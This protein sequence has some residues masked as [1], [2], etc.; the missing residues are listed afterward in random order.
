[1]QKKEI[2][3]SDIRQ[4]YEE[5]GDAYLLRRYVVDPG[6]LAL[7]YLIK[8]NLDKIN[9][10]TILD[11]GCGPGILTISLKFGG[12]QT[13][14]IDIA[15]SKLRKLKRIID[16]ALAAGECFPFKDRSMDIVVCTEVLEHVLYPERVIQEILRVTKDYAIISFPSRAS[17]AV[18]FRNSIVVNRTK[19]LLNR[20]RNVFRLAHRVKNNQNKNQGWQL[21]KGSSGHLRAIKY[22]QLKKWAK[23]YDFKIIEAVGYGTIC[24]TSGANRTLE[25]FNLFSSY[26]PL[27]RYF[28]TFLVAKI[29]PFN[30]NISSPLRIP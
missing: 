10:K 30:Q 13:I 15:K 20:A 8:T 26:L 23:Q 25:A 17:L 16:L 1:M 2:K 11:V 24:E 4:F 5:E 19:A 14:G 3:F 18:R 27:S 22:S 6:T 29:S 21:T 28:G 12:A 7:H 9:G